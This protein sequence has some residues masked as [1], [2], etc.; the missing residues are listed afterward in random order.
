MFLSILPHY[1]F[2]HLA[3]AIAAIAATA[4]VMLLFSV[5]TFNIAVI[6]SE[7]RVIAQSCLLWVALLIVAS[8]LETIN[9]M[10]AYFAWIV[11]MPLGIVIFSKDLKRFEA[12]ERLIWL[13][14][15]FSQAFFMF[16]ILFSP[17]LFVSLILYGFILFLLLGYAY[18]IIN[19]IGTRMKYTKQPL[20]NA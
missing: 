17:F 15:P 7:L 9:P 14:T 1:W 18:R 12:S 20:S 13:M 5:S 19:R 4:G 8:A 6:L 16:S 3:Y 2:E 11:I 10:E